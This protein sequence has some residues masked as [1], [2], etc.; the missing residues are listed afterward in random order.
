M[1]LKWTH[2]PRVA[3]TVQVS[4][5]RLCGP[6]DL[7]YELHG[8]AEARNK[9]LLVSGLSSS[10]RAWVNTLN[11]FLAEKTFEVCVFDNRGCGHSTQ[12]GKPFT[13]RDMAADALGLLEHL[14]W[15]KDVMLVGHSMG[16]MISME[17]VLAAWSFFMIAIG[18]TPL[19]TIDDKINYFMSMGFP[20]AWLDSECKMETE[21]K[22]ST[23]REATMALT[24]KKM[25][26]E[27]SIG[28]KPQSATARNLQTGAARG[29][30]ITPQRLMQIK[31]LISHIKVYAGTDDHM[32]D[33]S[34]TKRIATI[35][36]VDYQEYPGGGHI[37]MD[38]FPDEF[39]SELVQ[40]LK[41]APCYKA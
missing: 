6:N 16:G 7:Y 10:S 3:A 29:L 1:L 37:L 35:M 38:N 34:S 20:Q 23:N 18:V 28:N 12:E 4:K 27:R 32:I 36:E 21:K 30:E 39:N 31:E 13:V 19:K 24:F 11:Y 5:T 15:K 14:G 22:Y 9:V 26:K 40:F 25:V 33:V 2:P 17:L 41:A 8:P